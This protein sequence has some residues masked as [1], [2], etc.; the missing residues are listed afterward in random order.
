[1]SNSDYYTVE[2]CSTDM[3][4]SC[5]YVDVYIFPSHIQAVGVGYARHSKTVPELENEISKVEENLKNQIPNE[6]HHKLEE[7]LAELKQ[8]L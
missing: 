8:H 3:K 7:K 4:T 6:E 5:A 1:M 2:S